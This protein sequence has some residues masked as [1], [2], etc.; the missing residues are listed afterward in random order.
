MLAGFS[1]G[2]CGPRPPAAHK[3]EAPCGL[4][5]AGRQGV[6][7]STATQKSARTNKPLPEGRPAG[8]L[9]ACVSGGTPS[10][11]C[12]K[13]PPVLNKFDKGKAAGKLGVKASGGVRP[14][15]TLPRKRQAPQAAQKPPT[16]PAA[17]KHLQPRGCPLL[18]RASAASA[19]DKEV[20]MDPEQWESAAQHRRRHPKVVAGCARCLYIASKSSWECSYGSYR[21]LKSGKTTLTVWLAERPAHLGQAWA[22]GCV[23]CATAA[24]KARP[25]ATKGRGQGFR[26]CVWS[27]FEVRG[28][29]A[30]GL[31][32][33]RQHATTECHR[34]AARLFFAPPEAKVIAGDVLPED[35]ALFRGGVPQTA[36]YLQAWRACRSP[37]SFNNAEALG[38]TTNFIHGA[39]QAVATSR[40]AF[41]SMVRVIAL[42]I[43]AKKRQALE[44][45]RSICLSLDDRGAYRVIRYKTDLD[46]EANALASGC[47]GVLKRGGNASSKTLND[48]SADYSKMMMESVVRALQRVC[49]DED[50]GV[51]EALVNRLCLKVRLGVA[52]GGAPV[53]KALKFLAS[54]PM[55]NM[56]A[57]VHDH[58]HKIRTAT[59]EPLVRQ[60]A[61]RRWYDDLFDGRHAL[62]PDIK[63]SDGWIEKLVLCQKAVL[64]SQGVLAGGLAKALRTVT[65]AKQRFES[66]ATPQHQVC[67]LFLPI[68]M[69][70]ALQAADWRNDNEVRGRAQRALQRLPRYALPTGLAAT[71]S[72]E[73]LDF[74]RHF[75]VS[76][77][78]P[79]DT[80]REYRVW[81]RRIVSLF[82]EA[83]LFAGEGVRESPLHIVLEQ[84]KTAPP[85]FYGDR[86]IHLW[87][88]PTREE[89]ESLVTG[90]QTV[91]QLMLDR[92]AGLFLGGGGNLL[93][94]SFWP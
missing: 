9:R 26:A 22:L 80:W 50:G 37:V 16:P 94:D 46:P 83:N 33:I 34:Q 82:L 76:D 2:P 18:F 15:P 79:A 24:Q 40:R 48:I 89:R 28:I 39:R 11:A 57:V 70:L 74:I 8:L 59:K 41:R 19:T 81:R 43:R 78:D 55:P 27:K 52:D 45:T 92:F 36:D 5:C 42:T 29:G 65:F 38:V 63:N 3:R 49:E 13:I 86:V 7:A 44:E 85:I 77:H 90:I 30:I 67:C 69:L 61:F 47:L 64:G 1:F 20:H 35:R 17:E 32:G 71:Y 6:R 23:F 66:C 91:V 51:D 10:P 12:G 14:A 25:K 62:L 31:R 58:C 68:A 54:G 73:A 84:A 88:E 72:A 21:S 93:A 56:L 4:P 87:S 53:Q 75:D 60:D